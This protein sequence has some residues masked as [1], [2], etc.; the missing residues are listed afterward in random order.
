MHDI[1]QDNGV[2]NIFYQIPQILYS[3]IISSLINVLLKQLSLSE[4]NILEIKKL[5][6]D[7]NIQNN[8]KV[9][10]IQKYLKV[11]LILFF[12]F[13]FLLMAFFGISFLAFVL[14]I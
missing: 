12:I 14:Y 11:K 7:K 6:N 2:F 10:K 1:Y 8:E 13:S 5:E 3:S 4:K 9:G